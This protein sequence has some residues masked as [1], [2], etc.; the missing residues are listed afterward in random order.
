MCS[1]WRRETTRELLLPFFHHT[2]SRVPLARGK[3]SRARERR[4]RRRRSSSRLYTHRHTRHPIHGD[5]VY[6]EAAVVATS[7]STAKRSKHPKLWRAKRAIFDSFILQLTLARL[8]SAALLPH[9]HS[10][11]WPAASVNVRKSAS[12]S[13]SL[14]PSQSDKFSLCISSC[15]VSNANSPIERSN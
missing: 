14:S 5:R 3:Q 11:S 2:Q 15:S 13:L 6:S 8:A 7:P 1:H 4:R 9:F 10:S 12:I